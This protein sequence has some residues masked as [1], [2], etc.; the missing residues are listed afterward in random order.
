M[1]DLNIAALLHDIGKI[2]VPE[3]ILNKKGEL[4]EAEKRK[5]NEHPLIGASILEPIKELS[6]AIDGVKY[7]H[8]H[9]DG[10]GYPEGLKGESIPIISAIVAV[11]DSYD[12]MTTNRPYRPALTKK[13]A[14]EEIRKCSKVQFHPVVTKAIIELYTEGKL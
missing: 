11:A 3:S 2:G 7:H 9:F 5:I 4:N 13:Q 8:E 1:E 12:A 10:T 6:R 14:V